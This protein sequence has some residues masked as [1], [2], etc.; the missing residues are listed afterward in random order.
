MSLG[1]LIL[2]VKAGPLG[3]ALVV[4]GIVILGARAAKREV[5]K[6]K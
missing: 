2:S 5:Y 6:N 1:F 3:L 4:L